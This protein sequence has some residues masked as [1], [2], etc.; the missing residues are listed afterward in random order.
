ML[1]KPTFLLANVSGMNLERRLRP[2]SR[3]TPKS[4]HW[5][6]KRT[7]SLDYSAM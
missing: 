2:Y 4:Q 6:N 3:Q 5:E 1:H 7:D